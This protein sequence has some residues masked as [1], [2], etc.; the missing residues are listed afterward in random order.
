M[1]GPLGRP[2]VGRAGQLLDRIIAAMGLAREQVFIA[3]TVKCRPPGTRN[4]EPPEMAACLP[5]LHGQIELIG[6]KVIVALGKFSAQSLLA[7]KRPISR[8][9]GHFA[10]YRGIRLMPTFHPSSLLRNPEDKKLVWE[11]MQQVMALLGL[12]RPGKSG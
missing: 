3:N 2:F 10:D 7:S 6:P 11:D 12:E 8:L 1:K 9:R 4:P 5:Y